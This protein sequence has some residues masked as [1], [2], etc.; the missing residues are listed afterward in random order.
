M[1]ESTRTAPPAAPLPQ[2]VTE[3]LLALITQRSLDADY[4]HVAARRRTTGVAAGTKSAPR[5]TAAIVLVVFGLLVTVAAVQTSRNASVDQSSRASLID[6]IN[7]RR[8]GV[9]KLQAQ[10]ANQQTR[11]LRLRDELTALATA[12]QATRSRIQRLD[13]RTGFGAVRG[14]GVQITVASAPDSNASETVRDSDLALLTDALW[15]AGAEAISVNGER[16]TVLSAFRNVGVGILVNS[17]PVFPPYVF[18]VVGDPNE[19]P[20][21]LLSSSAGAAW[22]ALKDSFG[23]RFDVKNGGTMDLPAAPPANLRSAKIIPPKNLDTQTKGD[24]TS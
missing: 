24:S 7:L 9:A 16:L 17:Q 15:A 18:S 20:A 5:H 2:H 13:V 1:V 21:N 6:Q 3:P 19:L 10:L 12:Q 23:F 22:Y 14:P 11:Q 8:Q 4:E